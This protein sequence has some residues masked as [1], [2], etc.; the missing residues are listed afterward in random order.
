[1]QPFTS[2][3]CVRLDPVSLTMLVPR[4]LSPAS[5]FSLVANLGLP[6][7]WLRY[8]ESDLNISLLLNILWYNLC[9]EMR[10][11]PNMFLHTMNVFYPQ[12]F[13]AV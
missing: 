11:Y 9:N 1:M 6:V 7:P 12:K 13:C 5:V 10:N 4:V 2:L 8:L 3:T